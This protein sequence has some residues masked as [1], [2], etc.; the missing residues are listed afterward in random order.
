MKRVAII[1]FCHRDLI[2]NY[3]QTLQ[4]YALAETIRRLGFDVTVLSHRRRTDVERMDYEKEYRNPSYASIISR[5]F[6]KF[7]EFTK[8][9]MRCIQTYSMDEVAS[10]VR[11][12]DV[13]ICGSDAIWRTMHFD[14][15]YY[16][17]IPNTDDKIKV[18]YAASFVNYS[19]VETFVYD[20]MGDMLK[21][22]HY[23]STREV[24]AVD[25][26]SRITGR[27]DVTSVL[28]PTLLVGREF[29]DECICNTRVETKRYV[30]AYLFDD[31][32]KN[33]Q[34]IKAIHARYN[35]QLVFVYTGQD[36]SGR[37]YFNNGVGPDEFVNLVKN[38]EAVIT[39]SF[40]GMAFSVLYERDLYILKRENAALRND[41][42][43]SSL[44]R[45]CNL[46]GR[47]VPLDGKIE[48][49]PEVDWNDV[50]E[51]L[52]I[53]RSQSMEFLKDALHDRKGKL[54]KQLSNYHPFPQF[55]AAFSKDEE[56]HMD[57][58]SGG[59]FTELGRR[60]IEAGGMVYGAVQQTPLF[61]RHMRA[62]S[63]TSLKAMRKSK[64]RKSSIKECLPEI[65]AD[66]EDG[67]R[68]LFSGTGCQ[69]RA[70]QTYLEKDYDTLITCEIF[71]HGAPA[72]EVFESYV[73]EKEAQE[74]RKLANIDYRDQ[75]ESWSDFAVTEFYQDGK[76]ESYKHEDHPTHMLYLKGL[77]LEKRCG[78]C[79]HARLPRIADIT[80]GDFWRAYNGELRAKS[81]DNGLSLVLVNSIR[82]KTLWDSIENRICKEETT[83]EIAR[84][85]T[86][87]LNEPP[88]LHRNHDAFLELIHGYKLQVAVVLCDND[89][90]FVNRQALIV[91]H[92]FDSDKNH[93]IFQNDWQ[94]TIYFESAQG[95]L[96]GIMTYGDYKTNEFRGRIN[97]EFSCITL[98]DLDKRMIVQAFQKLP[99]IRRVPVINKF[100]ELM[101]ELRR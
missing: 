92:E 77:N 36:I 67:K 28:D 34:I 7:T 27:A 46:S 56:I 69:I 78:A 11:D 33:D 41:M 96:E 20:R 39:N 48:S 4:S 31:S 64:Y 82:G 99:N 23:I 97:R 53:W 44:C 37:S 79:V 25:L 65:V 72:D 101:G 42:R 87:H 17:N 68:V 3:G 10:L 35:A 49:M 73:A 52:N 89:Y 1:T 76:A 47:V 84:K 61:V 81:K 5:N 57:S 80:L 38:A 15:V 63:M 98:E 32:E 59:I 14:P 16:L 60:V 54:G 2:V 22:L 19:P 93:K 8:A 71:C 91:C 12:M 24:E 62:D 30:L 13:I 9:H 85:S 40:H 66:L 29:W 6:A 70:L 74:G 100:G 18:S 21:E 83:E 26:L 51:R 50:R 90:Q 95:V 94:E 43:F 58:S 86:L 88:T 45:I 55:Y 75:S